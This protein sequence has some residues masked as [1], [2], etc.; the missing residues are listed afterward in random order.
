MVNRQTL[1][2][3][4]QDIEQ[5]DVDAVVRALNSNFLTTGPSVESFEML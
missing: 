4:F 5:D 3:G 2:Y 1:P